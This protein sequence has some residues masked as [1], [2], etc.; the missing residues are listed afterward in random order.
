M[1]PWPQT[2]NRPTEEVH[3][4]GYRANYSRHIF[5]PLHPAD[6]AALLVAD[7]RYLLPRAAST[8]PDLVRDALWWH[9]WNL[10]DARLLASRASV[11]C[12]LRESLTGD[13]TPRD[14]SARRSAEWIY[15]P[16]SPPR[17]NVSD[18]GFGWGI[19]VAVDGDHPAEQGALATEAAN[20]GFT[21]DPD[22]VATLALSCVR[23]CSDR[24]C[25]AVMK[26]GLRVR[27]CSGRA[28]VH[29][30][31]R[32][33]SDHGD[34]SLICTHLTIQSVY[35]GRS[36]MVLSWLVGDERVD[37]GVDFKPGRIFDLNACAKHIARLAGIGVDDDDGRR[38]GLYAGRMGRHVQPTRPLATCVGNGEC[39]RRRRSHAPTC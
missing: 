17:G 21:S 36:A 34:H 11:E 10:P 24:G 2:T 7:P 4:R 23:S 6:L 18:R 39:F 3:G 13:T 37:L 9:M 33:H 19:L 8:N 1:S 29:P 28:Y 20:F 30:L 27:D 35:V 31:M 25:R 32:A 26:L 12:F 5:E 14:N 38:P 22:G 16:Q 15:R